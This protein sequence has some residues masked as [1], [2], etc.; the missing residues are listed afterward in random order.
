MESHGAA[1][2]AKRAG[3]PFLAIR[4]IADPAHRAL[5]KSALGAVAPDGSTKVVSTL[6]KAA[7]APWEFPALLQLGFDSD[8]ALI[9]LGR[10][11][12]GLLGALFVGLDL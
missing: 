4:A 10:N 8:R 1:R 2:A 3:V 5:P 7:A 6:M 12:G 9:A 11:L